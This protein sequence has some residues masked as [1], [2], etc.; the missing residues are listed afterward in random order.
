MTTQES[1]SSTENWQLFYQAG[2]YFIRNYQSGADLQLGL[3]EDDLTTPRLL[4]SSSALGQQ[5]TITARSDSTY[6]LTN[7]LVAN[8]SSLGI[9]PAGARVPAMD[10][11]DTDGH[12]TIGI[13]QSAGTISDADMLASVDNVVVSLM[14]KS[15]GKKRQLM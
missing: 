2:V 5:W 12:W 9:A 4:H 3:T 7:G 14:S 1:F 11:A 10:T 15:T 6:R 8:S 13:N